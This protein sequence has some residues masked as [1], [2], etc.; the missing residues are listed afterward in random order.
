M[1]V[2]SPEKIRNVVFL[3]HH[4][5]GKTTLAEALLFKAGLLTRQGRVEDGNTVSDYDPDEI[6]RH[7]SISLSLLPVPWKDTKINVLDTP[8]Y[9]DFVGEALAA[10][11]AADAA[12]I[13][14]DATGGVQVGTEQAWQYCQERD[15]P[16]A[17]FVNKMDRENAD[18]FRALAAIRERFGK[19]CVALQMPLGQQAA[20]KG[21]I[22][23]IS[24]R[25]VQGGEVPPA[26]LPRAQELREQVLEAVAETDDA[27]LSRYLEG[28]ELGQDEVRQA[29]AK[30]I[31]AGQLQPVLLGSAAQN[32][33]SGEL[34]AA[35][36]ALF[37]SP[38]EVPPVPALNLATKQT[39]ELTANPAGP[40]AA[41]VFKTTADPYVGR[42]TYLRVYSGTL[43]SDSHVWNGAK[44][45]EERIGQLYLVRGK[46][47]ENT[48][49]LA[50]GDIG[51][52]AKLAET[53][54]SDTLTQQDHPL[55]FPPIKFPLPLYSAAVHPKTK[56]DLDKLGHALARLAEEDPTI[57]IHREPDTSETILSGL[58]ESHI[59]VTVEKM[60]RKFGA[61]VVTAPPRVPYKETITTRVKAEYRHKKQT[62]GHGQY[63]HVVMDLEPLPRGAGFE[64]AS[65]VVGG[66]VPKNYVP[67][68]EKGLR[69]TLPDGPLAHFPLVDLRA[70]LVDGSYHDVDS[71]DMAFQIAASQA[72]KKGVSEGHPTLLE[73]VVNLR[74]QVPDTFTGEVIG[75]LNTKRTRVHGMLPEDGTTVI[76]AQGPL[77]ELQRYAT[78]L[79]SLT[80]G[81]GSFTTEF[82]HYEEVPAHL[83][84]KI[85]EAAQR[86]RE[87]AQK[88]E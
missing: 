28:K 9:A 16:R 1:A 42:L 5:A 76:E 52:V 66:S 8:G 43:K 33:G 73:P 41:F 31:R 55:A 49:Q 10:I 21:V 11:R 81:R 29:L 26:L 47:E 82:S 79:R 56:V 4:G 25:D 12:L 86:E 80:Q 50:A 84:P 34:L 58:G 13:L 71:S 51:A 38:L 69:S 59:Q 2:Y 24:L 14:V 65:K 40:L 48:P 57:S 53:A 23:L 20:F 88:G 19:G 64:F 37:P 61:G 35:L 83:A 27:L 3:S 18:F 7:I 68:V 67:A 17:F 44:K 85:A 45:R 15:L 78:D 70:T 60:Q 30:G 39:E 63:G 75:D 74:V 87:A 22:D 72:L 6:R 62:G 32:I 54:T 46:G 77:A 36:V